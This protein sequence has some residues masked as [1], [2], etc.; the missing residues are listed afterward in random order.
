[1]ENEGKQDGADIET[2]GRQDR[3][4]GT[5]AYEARRE[6]KRLERGQPAKQSG[7]K[8]IKM[9]LWVVPLLVC[10]GL[11]VWLF[12]LPR[13]YVSPALPGKNHIHAVL[14]IKINGEAYPIPAGIGLPP[15][16]GAVHVPGA[17]KVIHTHVENDQL[18]MEAVGGGPLREDDVKLSTFFGIWGKDFSSTSILG[19]TTLSGGTLALTV[20]GAPNTEFQNYMMHDGDV[21]EISYTGPAKTEPTPLPPA[22]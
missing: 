5:D 6:E 19:N 17:Q 22:E 1:M 4:S 12:T 9:A 15:G 21:I 20:N 13:K 16:G 14:T 3:S 10:V 7:R 18:H 11:V 2:T 8:M